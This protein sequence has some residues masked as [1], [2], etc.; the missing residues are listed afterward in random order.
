MMS[1]ALCVIRRNGE[2]K[3]LKPHGTSE[4]ADAIE[5]KRTRRSRPRNNYVLQI[6]RHGGIIRCLTQVLTVTILPRSGVIGSTKNI[7]VHTSAGL[8]P[9]V[10]SVSSYARHGRYPSKRTG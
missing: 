10:G 7:P 2:S 9:N 5:I 1:R 4:H 6:H 3:T 8:G